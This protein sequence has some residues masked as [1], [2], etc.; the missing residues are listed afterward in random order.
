MPNLIITSDAIQVHVDFGDYTS[1]VHYHDVSFRRA[2]I[3]IV[4]LAESDVFVK[5]VMANGDRF[6]VSFNTTQGALIVD[7]IN[8]VSPTSN[9]DLRTKINALVL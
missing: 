6:D 3:A 8:A 2:D 4:D 7:S 5:V 1:L 9:A